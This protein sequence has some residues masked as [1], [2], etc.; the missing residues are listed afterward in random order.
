MEGLDTIQV[1]F[2]WKVIVLFE[3]IESDA[4]KRKIIDSVAE[5]QRLKDQ[6]G[7]ES[8]EFSYLAPSIIKWLNELRRIELLNGIYF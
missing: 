6:Y 4:T 8:L 1:N 3:S 5:L 2:S 7:E